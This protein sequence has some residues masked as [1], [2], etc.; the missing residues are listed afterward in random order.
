MA[1][2]VEVGL[3]GAWRFGWRGLVFVI[4]RAL[5]LVRGD[6]SEGTAGNRSDKRGIFVFLEPLEACGTGAGLYSV[7]RRCGGLSG[8]GH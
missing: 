6:C 8:S 5:F 3:D 4:R 7:P 2:D 1:T